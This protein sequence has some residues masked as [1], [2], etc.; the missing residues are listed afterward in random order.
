MVS[1]RAS[2]L[3]LATPLTYRGTMHPQPASETATWSNVGPVKHGYPPPRLSVGALTTA[4]CGAELIVEGECSD[5]PPRDACA[6]CALAWEN[7]KRPGRRWAR[8]FRA[9]SGTPRNADPS[10]E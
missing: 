7:S 1:G 10:A 2:S 5:R 6:L 9:G 8:A 3:V 4:Y